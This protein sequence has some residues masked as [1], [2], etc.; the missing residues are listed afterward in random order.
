MLGRLNRNQ[1]LAIVIGVFSI[2][3]LVGAFGIRQFPLPRPIDSDLI[4]KVLGFLMLGLAL[5]LFFQRPGTGG[6]VVIA[7]EAPAEDGPPEPDGS[8]SPILQVALT[9]AA[10]AAYAA[11][12][13]LLGF[14][15]ASALLVGGLAALFGYRNWT[16]SAV[17]AVAV[18]LGLYLTLTRAMGIN[19]PA[20]ILPF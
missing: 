11:L 1:V 16:V 8:I 10:V 19:L 9:V 13:R 17:V 15:L 5:M 6:A 12:L 18:P 7:E 14:T 4:P 20:G 2:V 3:Y